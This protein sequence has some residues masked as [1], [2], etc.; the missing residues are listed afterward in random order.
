MLIDQYI[1]TVL[2]FIEGTPKEIEDLTL[3]LSEYLGHKKEGYLSKGETLEQA[4]LQTIADFGEPKDIGKKLSRVIFPQRKWLMSSM[5]VASILH[6][7][8]TLVLMVWISGMDGIRDAGPVFLIELGLM[9]AIISGNLFFQRK[10]LVIAR[11]RGLFF[12]HCLLA[13]ISMSY[14]LPLFIDI[15]T[16]VTQVITRTFILFYSLIIVANMIVGA[17]IKPIHS[18]FAKL[19]PKLKVTVLISNAFSGLF[20][21]SYLLLIGLGY[22]FF[23]PG[24]NPL[25][26]FLV[27]FLAFLV[28]LISIKVNNYIDKTRGIGI[29]LQIVIIMYVFLEYLSIYTLS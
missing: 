28:W 4:E 17:W 27:P 18:H 23:G 14:T 16:S 6:L 7:I 15:Q 24:V 3:E 25:S 10:K 26:F 19:S 12:S 5:T 13:L 1:Q 20:I 11:Y 29:V 8:V 2:S 22:L 9:I 21:I